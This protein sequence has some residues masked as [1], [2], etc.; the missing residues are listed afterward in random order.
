LPVRWIMVWSPHFNDF[1]E[2]NLRYGFYSVT[3]YH[4][5][6][7]LRRRSQPDCVATVQRHRQIKGLWTPYYCFGLLQYY[8]SAADFSHPAKCRDCKAWLA[9]L[10]PRFLL[11]ACS[12]R[13]PTCG[14][15]LSNSSMDGRIQISRY[16]GH[17]TGLDRVLTS[18]AKVIM[19]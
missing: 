13:F 7:F 11:P 15:Y 19:E 10:P 18:L 14:G 8:G 5:P 6:F 3:R 9:R 17:S 4:L 1:V 12:T 16:Q 2:A